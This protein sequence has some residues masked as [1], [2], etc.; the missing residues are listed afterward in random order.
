MKQSAYR[1]V[2]EDLRS[3]RVR[4][5]QELGR[6][7]GRAAERELVSKVSDLLLAEEIL[8]EQFSGD[9]TEETEDEPPR[10]TAD[11][12]GENV[13]YAVWE[14]D[15]RWE[16]LGEFRRLPRGGV[17]VDYRTGKETF[18]PEGVVRNEAVEHGD[19]LGAF[20][21]GANDRGSEMF[22]FEVLIR[23]GRGESSGR[24]S[25][26]AP[27]ERRGGEWGAYSDE[28]ETFVTVPEADIA[29]LDLKEGDLVEIGYKSG[30][31][32]SAKVAWKYDP[33]DTFL[34]LRSLRKEPKKERRD[35]DGAEQAESQVLAEKTILVVGAD[36]YK[37]TFKRV[38]ERRGAKFTWESGFMVGKFLESK[39][40][41]AHIVVIVTEAMKHKM[42]DVEAVCERNGK[43]YV[44]APSRGASGALREVLK[45]LGIEAE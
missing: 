33:G 24:L 1:T 22:Y 6:S 45:L 31:P 8:L 41:R 35:K 9:Q 28:D 17:L 4:I 5:Y 32:S 23:R 40:R 18:V 38:F 15:G 43:P 2:I 44:Y 3:A 26:V 20:R 19:I 21:K 11:P 37:E 29:H 7:V 42:P 34:Q 27:L 14:M 39:V 10:P 13:D 12:D 16:R 25:F 36:A 30:D